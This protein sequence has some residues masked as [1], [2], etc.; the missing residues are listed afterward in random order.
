M[1]KIIDV[2]FKKKKLNFTYQS[3]VRLNKIKGAEQ[4]LKDALI[5]IKQICADDSRLFDQILNIISHVIMSL[6]SKN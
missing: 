6:R 4:K 5:D 3:A 1:C 2:D